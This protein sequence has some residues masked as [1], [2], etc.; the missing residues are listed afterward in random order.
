MTFTSTGLHEMHG[1]WVLD[2]ELTIRG[3]TRS[4]EIGLEFL[5]LDPTGMQGEAGVGF[6]GRTSI[7]RSDFGIAFGLAEGGKIVV[8]DRVDILLEIEAVLVE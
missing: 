8:G 2:G 7:N 1:S 6:E 4:V 3:T 5:G